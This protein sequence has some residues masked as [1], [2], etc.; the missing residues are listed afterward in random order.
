MWPQ[1]KPPQWALEAGLPAPKKDE[2]FVSYV[3][4]LGIDAD[5]LLVEL[6]AETASL[7]NLR[8]G[9]YLI[10][11]MRKAFTRHCDALAESVLEPERRKM[12]RVY[13]ASMPKR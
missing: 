9:S 6:R 2:C 5:E 7:A 4:R 1:P 12:L 10:S 13:A 11:T 8:L 3:A